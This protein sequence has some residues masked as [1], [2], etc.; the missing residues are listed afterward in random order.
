MHEQQWPSRSRRV[1]TIIMVFIGVVVVAIIERGSSQ[2]KNQNVLPNPSYSADEKILLPIVEVSSQPNNP[3]SRSLIARIS[4]PSA[5]IKN[6]GVTL[7]TDQTTLGTG[8]AGAYPWSGPGQTGAWAMAGHRIGAGGPFRNLDAVKVG[9]TIS[10]SANLMNFTYR[11]TTVREVAP[12]DLSVLD[13]SAD[14]SEIVLITCTPVP[15]F[16]KRLV[17]TGVLEN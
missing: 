6:L 9:D 3:R 7:G 13:G 14:K 11:V 8:L 5:N 10:V 16:A 15:T 2:N 12:T 1:R 17:V 4:V